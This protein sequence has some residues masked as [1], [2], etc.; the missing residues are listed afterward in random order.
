MK[1]ALKFWYYK[2]DDISNPKV[3]NRDIKWEFGVPYILGV[4]GSIFGFHGGFSFHIWFL[5][6][7]LDFIT[8]VSCGKVNRIQF[9]NWYISFILRRGWSLEFSIGIDQ[10]RFNHWKM[11]RDLRKM[12]PKQFSEAA[13]KLRDLLGELYA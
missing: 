9:W 5:F 7:G 11:K 6:F 4:N 3:P 2:C 8:D 13:E 10:T 12:T 1:K